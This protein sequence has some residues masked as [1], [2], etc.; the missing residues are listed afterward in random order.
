MP[1][2][3]TAQEVSYSSLSFSTELKSVILIFKFEIIYPPPSNVPLNACG[4]LVPAL[5]P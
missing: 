3:P 1:K 2:K 4:S 5:G